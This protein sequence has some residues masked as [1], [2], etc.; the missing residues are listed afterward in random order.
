ME[1]SD[2]RR[3]RRPIHLIT[4]FSK[5]PAQRQYRRPASHRRPLSHPIQ[6]SAQL[7]APISDRS[8][9][10]HQRA[11]DFD[12]RAGAWPEMEKGTGRAAAGGGL[13]WLEARAAGN[14]RLTTCPHG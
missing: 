9:G 3:S 14:E 7:A 2:P 1:T 11:C 8:Q 6:S 4:L 12:V 13:L 5:L 10:G